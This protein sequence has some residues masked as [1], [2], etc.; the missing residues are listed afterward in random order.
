MEQ[1]TQS[2]VYQTLP[3]GILALW[4]DFCSH[5]Y[6][7]VYFYWDTTSIFMLHVWQNVSQRLLWL[8]KYFPRIMNTG[9]LKRLF[10]IDI[11]A[12]IYLAFSIDIVAIIYLAMW[13]YPWEDNYGQSLCS[14]SIECTNHNSI[15]AA[16]S[17]VLILIDGM[18]LPVHKF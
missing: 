3:N 4:G 15:Y 2:S 13:R 1:H 6:Q 18:C 7:I 16:R 9:M 11:V 14:I 10:S 12:I 8:R 5:M 17:S